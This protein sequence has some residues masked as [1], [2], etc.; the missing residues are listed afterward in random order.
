MPRIL[1][2]WGTNSGNSIC[3]LPSFQ[4]K[5]PFSFVVHMFA[6]LRLFMSSP[7]PSLL[8]GTSDYSFFFS[9]QQ[10]YTSVWNQKDLYKSSVSNPLF[11]MFPSVF[12]K[13]HQLHQ[14]LLSAHPASLVHS[15]ESTFTSWAN[16]STSF[17]AS[18]LLHQVAGFFPKLSTQPQ[19]HPRWCDHS[20]PWKAIF[21]A[22]CILQHFTTAMRKKP[23]QRDQRPLGTLQLEPYRSNFCFPNVPNGLNLNQSMTY[24]YTVIYHMRSHMFTKK[25]CWWKHSPNLS[26]RDGL[27]G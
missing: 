9:Y 15:L 16:E 25:T 8:L 21:Q 18:Q 23:C 5:L 3:P 14:S 4:T 22:P 20:H 12:S 1:V 11:P 26:E 17:S 10:L 27:V 2:I 6:D 24:I 13:P 19:V 7:S